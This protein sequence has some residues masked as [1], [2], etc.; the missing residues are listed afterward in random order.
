MQQA[1][2]RSAWAWVH[3]MLLGPNQAREELVGYL[4]DIRAKT[5]PGLL[6]QRLSRRLPS[7]QRSFS[8]HFKSWKR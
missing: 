2:Y 7:L 1:D 8:A 3:F 6:S 5:P 4:A